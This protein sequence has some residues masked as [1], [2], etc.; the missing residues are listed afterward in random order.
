MYQFI[1]LIGLHDF[2]WGGPIQ[3]DLNSEF[4]LII[5]SKHIIVVTKSY[6]CFELMPIA[7][8][9]RLATVVMLYILIKYINASCLFEYVRGFF[10]K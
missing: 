6:S 7:S 1:C 3:K 8:L 9:A 2:Y 5:W 4:G 10:Y